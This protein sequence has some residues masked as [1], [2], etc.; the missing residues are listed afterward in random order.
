MRWR[1]ST[2]APLD[3]LRELRRLLKPG[4]RPVLWVPLDRASQRASPDPADVNHHLY[5]WTPL[6]LGNLLT[7]A[8]Y[9]VREVAVAS[10]MRGLSGTS[11]CTGYCRAAASTPP[12]AR[13]ASWP[14]AARSRR[15]RD[16]ALNAAS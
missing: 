7:E 11:S 16:Q 9:A 3:E 5:T 12:A 6:L 2:L 1:S 4:G 8:D 15:A 14:A 13:G 10:H